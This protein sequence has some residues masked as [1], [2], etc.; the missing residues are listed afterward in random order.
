M[1]SRKNITRDTWQTM[2]EHKV[3]EVIV[4]RC[5]DKPKGRTYFWGQYNGAKEIDIMCDYPNKSATLINALYRAKIVEFDREN[6][7]FKVSPFEMI[8]SPIGVESN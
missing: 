1:L 6:H 3:G 2:P 5:V 4:V 7:K 8:S